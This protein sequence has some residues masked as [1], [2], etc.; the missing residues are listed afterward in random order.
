MTFTAASEYSTY[1]ALR[2]ICHEKNFEDDAYHA[3]MAA[4]HAWQ[5][6]VWHDAN[7][8]DNR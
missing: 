4:Y 1:S 7:K 8:E 3:M 2:T 5:R 6:A